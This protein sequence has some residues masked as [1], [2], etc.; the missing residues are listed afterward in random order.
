MLGKAMNLL[1]PERFRGHHLQHLS[2]FAASDEPTRMMGLV[3][4]KGLR[5]DGSE[6][7]LEGSI[8]QVTLGTG[9]VLIA[10]LRNVTDRNLA[11]AERL[12]ARVQLSELARRLM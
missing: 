8:S 9:K 12:A 11:D 3:H 4:I 10:T 5:A 2:R 1:L 6:L 7:D